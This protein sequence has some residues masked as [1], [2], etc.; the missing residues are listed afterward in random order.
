MGKEQT[1]PLRRR[2]PGE[3]E[4]LA[5]EFAASG[6][7]R[8][9]FCEGRGLKVSTLDAYRRRLRQRERDGAGADRWVAVDIAGATRPAAA[10]AIPAK[11]VACA[12]AGASGVAV[13]LAGGRR[14]ELERGFDPVTLGALLRVLERN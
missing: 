1:C 2:T 3:A 9:R 4:R 8:R 12:A 10:S 14:I 7:S 11:P 6:L 5:R 13:V